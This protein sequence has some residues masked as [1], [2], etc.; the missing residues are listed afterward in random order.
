VNVPE[1][2]KLRLTSPWTEV[3]RTTFFGVRVAA[4]THDNVIKC[5]LDED[6]RCSEVEYYIPTGTSENESDELR[7]VFAFDR[8]SITKLEAGLSIFQTMFI[9]I[10]VGVGAMTFNNDANKLLLTPIERMMTKLE[11][12]K[13]NP[14]SAMRLGDLEFRRKEFGHLDHKDRYAKGNFFQKAYLKLKHANKVSEPMETVILER[15]IIKLGCLLALC[16]GETGGEIIASYIANTPE[17]TNGA[18]SST[19]DIMVPGRKMDAII[20]FC[21]MRK[22]MSVIVNLGEDALLFVNRISEFVHEIIDSHHG[23]PNKNMG[24]SFLLAWR[25][26]DKHVHSRE[27]FYMHQR[28]LTDMAIVAVV[29]TIGKLSA[30]PE[31]AKYTQHESLKKANKGEFRVDVGF[32]LHAGWAIE[33]L[34]GSDHK[35]DASYVSPQVTLTHTLQECTTRYGVNIILAQ[36]EISRASPQLA[37]SCRLIDQVK[38]QTK[39]AKEPMRLYT[40]DLDVTRDIK[41]HR[42]PLKVNRFRL[43]QARDARKTEKFAD[44]YNMWEEFDK[45]HDIQMM[46]A[47]Y[48]P[49]FFKRFF[50]AYR[51]YEC[52]E[53]S[54]ARDMFYTCHYD[55]DYRTPPVDIKESKWPKDGPTRTLLKYMQKFNFECPE[56]WPGYRDLPAA[57]VSQRVSPLQ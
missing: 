4:K 2:T 45:D 16:F 52:G 54:V 50:T 34:I 31:L 55:P 35:I 32:A 40:V 18:V 7:M 10:A 42:E 25:F 47:S 28:K 22:F 17:V 49:E 14:M 3:C 9:C 11:C 19:V 5:S 12:I 27:K 44:N 46:R 15:T 37:A 39:L 24:C 51:N 41:H 38:V 8:R 29:R 23:S 57:A 48:S 6:L 36:S 26:D 13:D 53:W 56:D 1:D 33:G 30:C 20:G 21:Q 43:K